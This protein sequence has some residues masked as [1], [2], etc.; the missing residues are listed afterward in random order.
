MASQRPGNN[1]V[2]ERLWLLL[3]VCFFLYYPTNGNPSQSMCVCLLLCPVLHP[4]CVSFPLLPPCSSFSVLAINFFLLCPQSARLTCPVSLSSPP[5]PAC[6]PSFSHGE[7]YISEP[8][9]ASCHS[10]R[11]HHTIYPPPPSSSFFLS[12]STYVSIS[13]CVPLCFLLFFLHSTSLSFRGCS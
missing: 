4:L 5:F 8:C 7:Q 1:K 10:N 13:P 2:P 3:S 11:P 6:S 9:S 12:S